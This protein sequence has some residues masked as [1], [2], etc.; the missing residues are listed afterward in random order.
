MDNEKNT[1][2]EKIDSLDNKFLWPRESKLNKIFKKINISKQI[3][4][5]FNI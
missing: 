1:I 2:L 3:K 5:I 4:K